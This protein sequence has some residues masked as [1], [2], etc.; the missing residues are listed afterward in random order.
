MEGIFQMSDISRY[1]PRFNTIFSQENKILE[2]IVSRSA[3]ELA[4][5]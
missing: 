3:T 2:K 1:D 4:D 5:I